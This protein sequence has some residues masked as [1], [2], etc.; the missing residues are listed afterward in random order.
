MVVNNIRQLAYVCR[1]EDFDTTLRYWQDAIGAGPF[2]LAVLQLDNQT[3]RG[4]PTDAR[5]EAALTYVGDQ[6]VEIIRPLNDAPSPWTDALDSVSTVPP[7]GL[8]HH[9]LVETDDYDET[10]AGL[11]AGGCAEGWTADGMGDRRVAYLDGR[12][13]FGSWVEVLEWRPFSRIVTTTMR[14]ECESWDGT[15]PRRS[16]PDLIARAREIAESSESR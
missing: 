6:Q 4:E 16:Y 13:T 8:F 15:D 2:W 5:V 10:M 3:F 1:P 11:R 9:F 14:E 12:S 7:A